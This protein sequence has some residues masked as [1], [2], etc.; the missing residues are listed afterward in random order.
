MQPIIDGWIDKIRT[1]SGQVDN[2]EQFRDE[3]LRIM[4]EMDLQQYTN[5]MAIALSAANLSGRESVVS[6]AGNE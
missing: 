1:L 2:L 4:P 3:L 6:E 5:A